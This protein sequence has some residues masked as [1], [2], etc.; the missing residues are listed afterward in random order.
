MYKN[1]DFSLIV[2]K[3]Q[4]GKVNRTI[5]SVHL[6]KKEN[7]FMP[8]Q[9]FFQATRE[10]LLL[11]ESALT[12]GQTSRFG[13]LQGN[14]KLCSPGKHWALSVEH[15]HSLVINHSSCFWRFS[16]CISRWLPDTLWSIVVLWKN[17]GHFFRFFLTDG[18]ICTNFNKYISTF[19]IFCIWEFFSDVHRCT[20]SCTSCSETSPFLPFA[21]WFYVW[22][23]NPNISYYLY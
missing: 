19:Q 1:F 10:T 23:K 18:P 4:P 16:S 12:Q 20:P 9:C 22:K 5:S 14:E 2:G 3:S 7:S 17:A 6:K 15:I 13:V 11:W 21:P 8:F